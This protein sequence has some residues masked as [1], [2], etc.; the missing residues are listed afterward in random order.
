MPEFIRLPLPDEAR[1]LLLL[2]LPGP[3]TDSESISTVS[4][5]GRVTAEDM[6]APHPLPE[7][8]CS[9]IDGY[10]VRARD[11]FG[12]TD[13]LP[14]YLSLIG[15]VPMGGAPT[16]DLTSGRCALIH[17]GDMLPDGADAVVM[18]EYIQSA[19]TNE[20]E[21][22]RAVAEGENVIRV[23]EEVAEGTVVLPRG[24]LMR[25]AEIGGLM[26]LGIVQLKCH[27]KDSRRCYFIWR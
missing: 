21:V 7:F 3:I 26:A 15:E 16:F 13:S 9:T 22:I 11:T 17:A 12:A 18:L 8:P 25:P 2:H 27:Q 20:I 6:I 23:G 1:T 4:S 19:R 5:L 10:A 24:R 14:V